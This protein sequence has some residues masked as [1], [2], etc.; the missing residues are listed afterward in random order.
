ML[1]L[2][3]FKA[4][5]DRLG[6][7]MGDEL[8]RGL[9]A[10]LHART[11]ETDVLARLSGDEFALLMPDTDR[12][13][14]ETVAADVIALVRR[15]R[16]S[17]AG[18]V[19]RVTA[20]VGVALFDDLDDG[21]VLAL[22]DAAMYAAKESGGDQLVVFT[23]DDQATASRS[24]S[25]ANGLRRALKDHRFVLHCQPILNLAEG[26][27]DQYE[28][29]IR[30]QGENPGE[31]IAPSAFLYAAERFGLIGAIDTWV[32]LAS[33]RADRRAAAAWVVAS[34]LPSTYRVGR[35]V[36]RALP[37]TSIAS[38]TRVASTPRASSSS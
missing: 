36:T 18:E 6:H 30:M 28:L 2:D 27:I 3:G 10:D 23:S 37:R 21:Q 26:S 1:D 35:S 32:D 15:H 29:L 13:E 19:A 12:E 7:A 38:S 31:L 33:C 17:L 20:S 9:A 24:V 5:N 34:C 8:L 11:R 22:A 4:V 14:A 25:E 16:A